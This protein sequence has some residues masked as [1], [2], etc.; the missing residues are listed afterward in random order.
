MG[1]RLHLGCPPSPARPVRRHTPPL[2][3]LTPPQIDPHRRSPGLR[4]P[5]AHHRL[6][7]PRPGARISLAARAGCCACAPDLPG[8]PGLGRH[9]ARQDY[10]HQGESEDWHQRY[11][12]GRVGSGGARAFRACGSVFGER[13]KKGA[14]Q[15]SAA[16]ALASRRAPVTN[17]DTQTKLDPPPHPR[18]LLLSSL[19]PLFPPSCQASAASAAW[20]SGSASNGTTWRSSPS[21]TPSSRGSTWPTC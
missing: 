16:A 14:S 12:R 18:S 8:R 5:G 20:S 13:E 21:T 2:S 15:A 7:C 4:P 6:P 17:N 1:S 19:S 11:A 3:L 10:R 9:R